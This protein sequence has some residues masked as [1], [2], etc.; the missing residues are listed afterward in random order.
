MKKEIFDYRDYKGYLEAY[1]RSQPKAGRG[2]RM[3]IAEHIGSPVSHIS[4]VLNGNSHL[5]M[6]Q[7]EGV[8]EFLGHT[9]DE[10]QFF[11][12]LVQ[13]ARAGTPALRKRISSQ[14]QQVLER[15]LVLKDRLGI[16]SLTKEDQMEFYSS[17][18]YGAIHVMLSIP[19]MQTKEAIS[20][21]LGISVKRT[22]EILEFLVSIGLAKPKEK[23]RYEI[24]TARIHLGVDS[25]LISKFHTNWRMKAIQSLEKE[26]ASEDLHYSSVVTIS[27]SDFINIKAQLVKQ[28]ED[29]KA[30]IKS[31]PEEGVHC[32]NIDFFR[33]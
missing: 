31:S 1:I 32:F 10:A 11:L 24:G 19:G 28:I 21:Y 30:V 13:L 2:L 18:V 4:Q 16:K 5:T 25:P 15:R 29:I 27:E 3:A 23:G 22:A 20:R 7:A 14:M 33:I 9:Q 8:N 26:N 6:E 12:F 17:W